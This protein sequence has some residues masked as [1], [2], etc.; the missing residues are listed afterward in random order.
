[1]AL[2]YYEALRVAGLCSVATMDSYCHT[3]SIPVAYVFGGK[4]PLRIYQTYLNYH[5]L[6]PVPVAARSKA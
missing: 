5:P 3:Y 4:P 6:V 1:M 2:K